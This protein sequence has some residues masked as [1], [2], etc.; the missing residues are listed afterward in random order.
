MTEQSENEMKADTNTGHENSKGMT[1]VGVRLT[2]ELV[3][4]S[5]SMH[6]DFALKRRRTASRIGKAFSRQCMVNAR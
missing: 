2:A 4:I 6:L 3:L 5:G 1:C